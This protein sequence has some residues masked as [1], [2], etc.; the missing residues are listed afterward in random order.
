VNNFL[1]KKLFTDPQTAQ[2]VTLE[3]AA[4]TEKKGFWAN[5]NEQR[6]KVILDR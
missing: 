5:Y 3:Q 4:K 1:C 2:L 6:D